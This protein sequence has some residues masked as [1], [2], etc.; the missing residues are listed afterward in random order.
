MDMDASFIEA[1]A[2]HLKTEVVQVGGKDFA[3]KQVFN[4]PDPVQY[5]FPTLHAISLD[6]V[7]DYLRSNRD[8]AKKDQIQIVVD[9]TRVRVLDA[10]FGALRKR[11]LF[12]S[13]QAPKGQTGSISFQDLESVRLALLTEFFPTDTL[14]LILQFMSNVVSENTV[15]AEDDGASQSV[16]A[17][18][19]MASR[20]QVVVPSPVLLQPMRTFSEVDQ[21]DVPFVFRFRTAPTGMQAA[22]LEHRS[23][24]E[25]K[26]VKNIKDWL[27]DQPDLADITIIG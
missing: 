1:L 24:W 14:S 2:E 4:P 27:R 3:T 9:P 22:L 7:A 20:A 15:H 12:L 10:P 13:V 25:R 26:A 11:D 19:G 23:D 5:E 16:T 18:V 6:A 8:N 17:K 21:P